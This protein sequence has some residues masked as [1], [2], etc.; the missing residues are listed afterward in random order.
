MRYTLTL[1]RLL[2]LPPAPPPPPGPAGFFRFRPGPG[3]PTLEL[4]RL[5]FRWKY[6]PYLCQKALARVL[7]GVLPL[8]VLLV[9]SLDDFMLIDT[10]KGVLCEVGRDSVRTLVES[11]FLISPKSVLEPVVRVSFRGKALNLS[12]RTVECHTQAPLQLWVGWMRLVVDG[13]EGSRLRYFGLLNWHVRPR[14]L[15]CPLAAGT[16]CWLRWGRT[17]GGERQPS[18]GLPLKLL[19]GLAPLMAVAVEP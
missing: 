5:P 19:H 6:S 1:K 13:D 15:G 11:G 3:M 2:V 12:P 10:D 14:G 4:E 17:V 18:Q 7:Q 9:H 16:W 8:E